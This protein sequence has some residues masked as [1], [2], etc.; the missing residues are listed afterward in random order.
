MPT[1]STVKIRTSKKVEV[2]INEDLEIS[3]QKYLEAKN[4]IRKYEKQL[5]ISSFTHRLLPE[6]R[7]IA[8]K[9]RHISIEDFIKNQTNS[10]LQVDCLRESF[11][12]L[13]KES[14][15]KEFTFER[16]SEIFITK[17]TK[18]G[19]INLRYFPKYKGFLISHIVF[20]KS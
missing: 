14:D 5:F 10:W 9:K 8:I 3:K 20:F 15:S 17:G 19:E 7:K 2:D 6:L 18:K 1:H 11:Q 16:T 4:I 13:L 12:E